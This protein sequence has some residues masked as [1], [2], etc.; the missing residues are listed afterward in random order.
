MRLPDPKDRI[1][2]EN[3]LH[4][5]LLASDRGHSRQA[6]RLLAKVLARDS[7]SALAYGQIGALELKAGDYRQA[8]AHLARARQ[9]RPRDSTSAFYQ[10]QA[11]FALGDYAGARQAL[12]ASLRLLP[13]QLPARLLLART[14]LRLR[15]LAAAEDQLQAALLLDPQNAEARLE[16]G[17]VLLREKNYGEAA[18]DLETAARQH[19]SREAFELLQQAY[20]GQGKMGQAEAAGRRAARFKRAPSAGP[21]GGGP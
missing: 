8:A 9:L 7:A 5:A 6:R 10:G 15:Q 14:D 12:Q 1:E 21:S 20:A 16:L 11:L 3:L 13:E 18:Q 2:E 4:D 17:R 19:P